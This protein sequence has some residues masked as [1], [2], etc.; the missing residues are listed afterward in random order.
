M[1]FKGVF[2]LCELPVEE[3]RFAPKDILNG[4]K[5]QHF[6]QQG[7]PGENNQR[8]LSTFLC[9]TVK[10]ITFWVSFLLVNF[11]LKLFLFQSMTKGIISS[12]RAVVESKR[13]SREGFYGRSPRGSQKLLRSFNINIIIHI[14]SASQFQHSFNLV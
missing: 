13:V 5:E 8:Y 6:I 14:A 10:K 3:K 11:I 7:Y 12:F 9:S 4:K 1:I 2:R